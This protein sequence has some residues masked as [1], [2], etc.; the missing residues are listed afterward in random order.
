M[1]LNLSS[2]LGFKWFAFL[3]IVVNVVLLFYFL[4]S[5]HS[6]SVI[7]NID[8]AYQV[9]D[10][11]EIEEIKGSNWDFQKLTKF[12]KDLSNKKGGEY[13]YHALASAANKGYLTANVDTH[14]LGHSVGDILYKQKGIEGIKVCT[15]DL[16]N[17]C[18]HSIVVG[19]LLDNGEESLMKA[20][21]TCKGAPG[22][23]GAYTMCVHGLGHG[24]L[25]YTEYDMKRAVKL[26]EKTGTK[27]YKN[28][29]IGQ[30]IGGVS[31]E[32]MAGV[33]DK[34]MWKKQVPNYFK[35]ED[36]L[37]PCSSGFIP[38]S[39]LGYCYTYLTPRLF[40]VS[41]A[42]LASPNPKFFN[43]AMSYCEAIPK[44]NRNRATCLG[45]FGKEYIVLA[46]ARNIQSVEKMT[47]DQLKLV[48]TWCS[49][50]PQ[51]GLSPCLGSALQSLYWGG[52]NDPDVSIR[53]CDI[54]PIKK[55]KDACVDGLIGS[56]GYYLKSDL[57]Y[58]ESFC[59]KIPKEYQDICK[60]KL[61][62]KSS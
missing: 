42:T 7:S 25:G 39:G 55:E 16:R 59:E 58:K 4:K 38:E 28:Q 41:G 54:I 14:L 34:E 46:N 6:R 44:G 57:G 31:M 50:G 19:F 47:N 52:E 13:G 22:G 26:C 62:T 36:P 9:R 60:S 61:L 5:P 20:V 45:S 35:K 23:T 32:M 51:E 33:H 10:F 30:C 18:S 2:K 56:V 49:L 1:K 12:F 43:K 24:V 15:D 27:E 29:E 40:E 37:S 8:R 53:F 11:P 17:A 3:L 48:Y 21:S